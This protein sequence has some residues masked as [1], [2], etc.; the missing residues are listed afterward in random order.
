MNRDL[1][2]ENQVNIFPYSIFYVYYEQYLT[3]WEETIFSLGISLLAVFIVTFLLLG[4][5]I[6]SSLIILLIIVMILIDLM[7][8]MYWW[9]IQLNG[10][11]LM[12]LMVA[13]GISVEFCAHITR[14]FSVTMHESKIV[15][16]KKTL[17]TMGSSVSNLLIIVKNL[18]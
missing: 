1:P 11:T 4:L 12:N 17:V 18:T 13:V 2:E 9:N 15:R 7:G 14:T 5:D 8:L 10:V 16:S 6:M 3:M